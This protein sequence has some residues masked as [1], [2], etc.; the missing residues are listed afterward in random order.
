MPCGILSLVPLLLVCAVCGYA[1]DRLCR[2]GCYFVI[3]ALFSFAAVAHVIAC[4]KISKSSSCSSATTAVSKKKLGFDFFSSKFTHGCIHCF[5]LLK[6]QQIYAKASNK[7]IYIV[8][9]YIAARYPRTTSFAHGENKTWFFPNRW[10]P[11][12][13]PTSSYRLCTNI[14]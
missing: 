6:F 2:R 4:T 3:S 9:S 13:T 7:S 5:F 11:K 12:Q 8:F 10:P 14:N 1:I